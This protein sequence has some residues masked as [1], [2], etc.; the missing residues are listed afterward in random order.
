MT[1]LRR[2]VPLPGLSLALL[3]LWLLLARSAS[4]G[5]LALGLL[6][7]LAIPVLVAK[8]WPVTTRVR[9]PLTILR[10]ALRVCGDVVHSNLVVAWGVVRWRWHRPAF[11]FVVIP[12]DLHDPVGL[13]VLSMVTTV[14]P[15]TVWSELAVDRSAMLLHVWD[16][17]DADAF[18]ARYKARYEAPLREIFE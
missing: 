14:V 3:A 17:P 11:K 8:F 6:V 15:G 7:A 1:F 2:I 5:Q 13:A 4:A 9:R 16:A 10:Y 12:L 18:V